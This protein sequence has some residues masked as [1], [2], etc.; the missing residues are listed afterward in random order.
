MAKARVAAR[1]ARALSS[2][3]KHRDFRIDVAVKHRWKQRI[4]NHRRAADDQLGY[5]VSNAGDV[6]GDG[7]DD[8]IAG[9]W[10]ADRGLHP[11][12]AKPT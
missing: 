5:S 12:Q 3:A 10:Q 2:L 8:L 9:A 7:F 4:P 1:R 11:V 6:N